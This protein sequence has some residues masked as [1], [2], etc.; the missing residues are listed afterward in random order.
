M[1]LIPASYRT[2]IAQLRIMRQWGGVLLTLITVFILCVVTFKKVNA[3]YEHKIAILEKNKAIT[4]QQRTVLQDMQAS[5]NRLVKK[6]EVLISL[7]GGAS[8]NEMFVD[9]DKAL[10]NNKVWFKSWEFVRAGS[11]TNE[12]IGG[13][14]TGYFIIIPAGKGKNNKPE[15]WKIQTHMKI[16]GQALDHKAL[17]SFV[18][19][20]LAQ[21]QI[22]DVK[23]I[24]TQRNLGISNAMVDFNIIVI[25][26]AQLRDA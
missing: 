4:S 6:Q 16:A 17:S 2:Y 3:S 10:E 24:N 12:Q 25:V 11:K 14:N 9:I 7:R 15:S 18:R 22:H 20:L 8:A 23:V 1:D 21:P 26:N 19:R 5:Y 13:V